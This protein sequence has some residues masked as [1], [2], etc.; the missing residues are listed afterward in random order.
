M[1]Q[2]PEPPLTPKAAA[3]RAARQV[4]EAAALRDNLRRR[5]QQATATPPKPLA[6]PTPVP[7]EEVCA[8]SDR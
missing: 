5:K 1:T 2:D 8:G 3:D 4:R 6:S 7:D